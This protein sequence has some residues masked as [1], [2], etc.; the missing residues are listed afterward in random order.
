MAIIS[1]GLTQARSY[2]AY[3]CDPGTHLFLGFAENKVAVEADLEAGKAY[4]IIT[5]MRLG[6]VKSRMEFTPV[7]RGSDDWNKVNES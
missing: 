6:M 5:N 7:T 3:A 1:L 4:Y 2:F